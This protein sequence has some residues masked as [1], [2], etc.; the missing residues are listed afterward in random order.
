[1]KKNLYFKTLNFTDLISLQSDAGRCFQQSIESLCKVLDTNSTSSF[2]N[3]VTEAYCGFKI[4]A[5]KI[6]DF[7][8]NPETIP[9]NIQSEPTW[10]ITCR[11][12]E[13]ELEKI[14][15]MQEQIISLN[16]SIEWKD[17]EIRKHNDFVEALQSKNLLISNKLAQLEMVHYTYFAL[18]GRLKQKKKH[19]KWRISL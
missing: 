4:I 13:N 8:K 6:R 16:A 7:L 2:T 9:E 14:P 1:M 12:I 11:S 3:S 17:S 10:I 19:F 18:I 5:I 15:E